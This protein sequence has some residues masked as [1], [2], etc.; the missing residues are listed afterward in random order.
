MNCGV[1]ERVRVG[2][3]P[4]FG[5]V[6]EASSAQQLAWLQPVVELRVG[7][8]DLLI[9]APQQ[10]GRPQLREAIQ[11]HRCQQ[12]SCFR[13]RGIVIVGHTLTLVVDIQG[14]PQARILGSHTH[15]AGVCMT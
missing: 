4:G 14:L 9:G 10:V 13:D 5:P 11:A 7:L 6:V 12:A 8:T 1:V 15:R 2:S 3:L